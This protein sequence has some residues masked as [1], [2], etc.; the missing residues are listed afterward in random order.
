MENVPGGLAVVTK[1]TVSTN[2]QASFNL[3]LM[4]FSANLSFIKVTCTFPLRGKMCVHIT[5][6]VIVH[7]VVYFGCFN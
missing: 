4:V 6:T 1:N 7:F 3:L 5:M 2:L